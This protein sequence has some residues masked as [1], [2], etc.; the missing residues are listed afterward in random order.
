MRKGRPIIGAVGGLLFG[1][2]VAVD[3]QQ[4]AIRPLDSVSI[5]G[6]P[7]AGLAVGIALGVL[8]PLRPGRRRAP[9]GAPPAAP[10]P[11]PR[12]PVE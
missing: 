5:L 2:F 6:L 10:S 3:L 4:Y 8:H 12:P 1:L 9:A 7:F 11:D